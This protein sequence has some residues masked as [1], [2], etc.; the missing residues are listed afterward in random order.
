MRDVK[1]SGLKS[2]GEVIEERRQADAG[3][4]DEWDRTAFAREVAVTVVRYRAEQ[5]ISQRRLADLTGLQQPAIARLERG[6][7]APGLA[8]LARLTRATGLTFRLEIA[9]G[10]A[11]L[12]PA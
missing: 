4:L 9:N 1:L 6:S 8:T 10:S 2:A 12:V 7:E 5:G 11:G 3:F